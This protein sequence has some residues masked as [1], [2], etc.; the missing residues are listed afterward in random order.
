M[1]LLLFWTWF[2]HWFY[3]YYYFHVVVWWFSFIFCF[4]FWF[5]WI[6]CMLFISAYPV[7]QICWPLPISTCFRLVVSHIGL[8]I[9]YTHTHKR[10][11]FP[12]SCWL[13]YLRLQVCFCFVLFFPFRTLNI[14]CYSFWSAVFLLRK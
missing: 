10:S 4:S 8:N 13:E 7:F 11:T 14:S 9:F 5:L 2:S 3:Y 12:Y 1:Y 6:H